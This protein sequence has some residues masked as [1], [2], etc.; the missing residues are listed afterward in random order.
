M[1]S[2]RMLAFGL[3][4]GALSLGSVAPALADHSSRGDLQD[5]ITYY[6]ANNGTTFQRS[7]MPFTGLES[8]SANRNG[9]VTVSITGAPGYADSGFA[10]YDG[11]LGGLTSF[12]LNGT[13]DQYGMNLWFD[14]NGDGEFFTWA[15]NVYT[16]V[17]SDTYGL[18]P[19]S[20][21]DGTLTVNDGSSFYLIKN[22]MTYTL[23]QLKSGSAPGITS[24][25]HIAIWV[26]VTAP[27]GG[28]K[29]ATVSLPRGH[30]GDHGDNHD[31]QQGNHRHGDHGNRNGGDS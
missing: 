18:G 12:K 31:G 19:A 21:A 8:Q 14:V 3:A 10:I 29:T 6:T 13:G 22:G 16:G 17:G 11:T 25:T 27:N 9:S 5:R 7:R 23:A 24:A 15:G 30:H 2:I 20:A 28:S 4:A 1:R 26:G